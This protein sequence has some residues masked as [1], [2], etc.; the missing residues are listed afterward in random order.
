MEVAR[1]TRSPECDAGHQAG[2]RAQG[3]ARDIQQ[4]CCRRL[5]ATARAVQARRRSEDCSAEGARRRANR[6]HR[7]GLRQDEG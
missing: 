5:G 7:E 3:Q 4:L 1:A 6:P 2:P